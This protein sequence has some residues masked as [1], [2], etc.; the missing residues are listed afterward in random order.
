MNSSGIQFGLLIL[1]LS[2]G[3]IFIAHG[4]QKV[5]GWWGGHGLEAT[6]QFM[7][8]IGIP[9]ILVYV[10]AFTEFLGGIAIVAGLFTRLAS[11]GIA[12]AMGVAVYKVHWVNGF[13][14]SGGPGRGPGFEYN[15]ALIGMALCLL[16][17]GAGKVSLDGLFCRKSPKTEVTP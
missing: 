5:M 17:A 9:P 15:L 13:F 7:Q 14:L 2:L 1:R 16:F 11:L 3:T 6:V 10:D 12:I 4:G 8:G